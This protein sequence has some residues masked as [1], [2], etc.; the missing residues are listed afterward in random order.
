MSRCA[1]SNPAARA[2]GQKVHG[3]FLRLDSFLLQNCATQ[4]NAAL[5]NCVPSRSEKQTAQH[6][7]NLRKNSL[8]NYKSAALDQ[9]SYANVSAEK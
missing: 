9:L 7:E 2:R 3:R 4:R 6:R 8:G 1:N 5:V